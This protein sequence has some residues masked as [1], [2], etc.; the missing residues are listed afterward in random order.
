MSRGERQRVGWR[1]GYEPK[2]VQSEAGVLELAVP[3]LRSTEEPFRPAVTDR[4]QTRTADLESLVRGMY[5][6]GLS[7]QDVSAL[8]TD[9]FGGSRLSKSTVSRVTQQLNQEFES[10]RQRD[11]KDLRVVYLFLDGQ[12]HAARQG[13]DEKEGVLSAYALLDD[14]QPVLLHLDLGPRESYERGC[15]FCRTWWHVDCAPPC[16]YW[17]VDQFTVKSRDPQTSSL[18]LPS[19]QGVSDSV[20]PRPRHRERT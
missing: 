17:D 2:R 3:Q 13:T 5:V 11:L 14:G 15:R 6:R 10:W 18:R 19:P 4:L 20:L 8:Y 7:T 1:N 12:Y 16:R 9:T